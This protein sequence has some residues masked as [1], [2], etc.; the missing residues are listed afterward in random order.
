MEDLQRIAETGQSKPESSPMQITMGKLKEYGWSKEAA[1]GIVGNL[2]HESGGLNSHIWGDRGSSYGLAQWNGPRRKALAEFSTNIGKPVDDIDTQLQFLNHELMTDYSD[3]ADKLR[4]AKTPEDAAFIFSRDYERPGI[5]AMGSR[6]WAAKKAYGMDEIERRADKIAAKIPI[7]KQYTIDDLR[8]IA[9]SEGYSVK[10]EYTVE[11]L[12]KIAGKKP[13]TPGVNTTETLAKFSAPAGEMIGEAIDLPF[14]PIRKGLEYLHKQLVEP[15]IE[16]T[17]Q[18]WA[19]AMKPG[20]GMEGS[21]HALPEAFAALPGKEHFVPVMEMALSVPYLKM[22]SKGIGLLNEFGPNAFRRNAPD[23]FFKYTAKGGLPVP[24]TPEQVESKLMAMTGAERAEAVKKYP[25]FKDIMQDMTKAAETKA[26][27]PEIKPPV[28]VPPEVP[29]VPSAAPKPEAR[30]TLPVTEPA[31]QI[32]VAPVERGAEV[33]APEKAKEPWEMSR[34][35]FDK[36]FWLH[37][38]GFTHP[39]YGQKT[40]I[41]GITKSAE[42]ARAFAKVRT[43]S[44]GPP[45]AGEISLIRS[46]DIPTD[47]SEQIGNKR[48][49]SPIRSI[50]WKVSESIPGNTKD[51]HRYI[52]EQAIATDKPVPPEVLA[53][54]PDLATT[55]VKKGEVGKMYSFPGFDTEDLLKLATPGIESASNMKQGI[56]SL[57]LPTANSPEHLKAAEVLGSKLGTMHRNAEITAKDIRIDSKVFDKL[58]VH[59]PAIPLDQNPGVKFM[60]DMSQGRPMDPQFQN[61]ANKVKALFDDRLRQLE[62][63]GVPLENVRDNYF[64]G[65]WK[66][67]AQ[68]TSFM[69]KRPFKGGE[70]FRKQKVFDDIMEGVQA[71]FEP[72][73]NNPIDLVKLKLAEMDRSIMANR[74]IKEWKK[75]GDI[76][77]NAVTSKVPDGYVKINDRYGTVY[78]PPIEG[79]YGRRIMGYYIAKEPVADIMN[80]YLS[81]S[82]YNSPYFGTAFKSWMAVA[83]SLNQFQLGVFSGFHAGFT[84]IETQITAGAEIFKDIYGV[85]KGNRSIGDLSK[86]IARYPVAMV[87]T[88]REGSKIIAEWNAPTMDVATN[89]AVGTLPTDTPSRVAQIA[90][91][92]EIAG[93]GFKMEQGLRTYQSEAMR[94][95]WYGGEKLKAAIRSPIALTELGMKPIMEFLVPRQKAGVFGEMAG[96]IISQN[97]TKTMEELRP[98]FRQAWNR[99]DARLGQVRYD[100]LFTHNAAKNFIQGLVRAPGWTGGT[101]AEVGGAPQDAAKFIAEWMRTGKAPDNMPDRVAYVLSLVGSMALTNGLLTYAFTGEKPQGIDYFAFRDGGKDDKGNPTR[102]LLPSYMKD[103]YAW[104]KNP[105]HTALAKTH[106]LI[107]LAGEIAKNRDYYNNMIYDEEKG[108]VNQDSVIRIGTH[109]AKAYIPFWIRG[110]GEIAEREGGLKET[111]AQHPG[112]LITPQIGIMPATRSYTQTDLDEVM[113][114]YNKTIITRTPEKAEETKIRRE[115]Q[116]LLRKGKEDLAI[117]KAR[118]AIKGKKVDVDTAVNWFKEGSKPAKEVQFKRLPLEWQAKALLKSNKEEYQMLMPLMIDKIGR[119][120]A[121]DLEKAMPLMEQLIKR[122]GKK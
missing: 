111:I 4:K 67:K 107:S 16:R 32:P 106:P 23:F 42:E 19:E 103:I 117:E 84:S 68:A 110:A 114:K 108:I 97:P 98:Q 92:T 85:I 40:T 63:A 30:V 6:V 48:S 41:G 74:A 14:V 1:A 99:V 51:P 81:S 49:Y 46:S 72:I 70:F 9:A 60:S 104:Y 62:E 8:K 34:A 77:F 112:K 7:E 122:V 88:S 94:R 44:N 28:E 82:L 58:G 15:G 93:G 17:V 31:L 25:Q 90:K 119:T 75:K 109:L 47:I 57:L 22:I 38:R 91:A 43:D 50:D 10:K 89:V 5:P 78:G 36:E 54:Y 26:A 13:E 64:P 73:S 95:N 115:T 29:V 45:S 65:M 55:I 87:N 27:A 113:N 53:D 3:V 20:G 24:L 35:D 39:R 37:G 61:I 102:F 120:K 83:N 101:I 2:H 52:V 21:G 121:Q 100:R 66:D 96:R 11:D 69:A 80:N 86:S 105:A 59:D 33:P 71:G 79:E 56:Q 118:N 18:D 12:Q 76:K 116:S